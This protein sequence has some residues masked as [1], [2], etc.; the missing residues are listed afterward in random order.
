MQ[1]QQPQMHHVEVY[2]QPTAYDSRQVQ[3]SPGPMADL[4]KWGATSAVLQV[5]QVQFL[6]S[7]T[8]AASSHVPPQSSAPCLTCVDSHCFCFLLR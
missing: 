2:M 4:Y 1:Q 6:A 5:G 3:Y 8:C 7:G